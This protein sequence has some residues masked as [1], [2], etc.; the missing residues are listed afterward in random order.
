[1][2]RSI[3]EARLVRVPIAAGE[4]SEIR[5]RSGVTVCV[6]RAGDVVIDSRRDPGSISRRHCTL[7]LRNGRLIVQN[8]SQNGVEMSR[9]LRGNLSG[10]VL[11]E[12]SREYELLKGH[13]LTF[14]P[15]LYPKELC[16]RLCEV[17][18]V[19]IA[20]PPPPAVS[21]DFG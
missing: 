5:V 21:A 9:P 8:L 15:F 13:T 17:E 2:R 11:L 3:Q 4:P 19:L 7:T 20:N 14:A 18:S 6:G 12:R 10:S 1:M 16:F